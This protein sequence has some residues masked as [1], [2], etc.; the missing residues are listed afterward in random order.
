MG[1]ARHCSLAAEGPP[2]QN[3]LLPHAL[4][5]LGTAAERAAKWH[6]FAGCDVMCSSCNDL[7]PMIGDQTLYRVHWPAGGQMRDNLRVAL[8]RAASGTRLL[9]AADARPR[10][11]NHSSSL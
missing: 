8:G 4:P 1:R 9:M 6:K 7:W 3:R 11:G 2:R 5:C 10:A